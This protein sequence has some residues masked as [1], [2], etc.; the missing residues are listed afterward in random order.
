MSHIIPL[1]LKLCVVVFPTRE[2]PDPFSIS[3]LFNASYLM[4]TLSTNNKSSNISRSQSTSSMHK[5]DIYL[6]LKDLFREAVLTITPSM[7]LCCYI[8]NILY[9]WDQRPQLMAGN[10]ECCHSNGGATAI[11]EGQTVGGT[12][13]DNKI[14]HIAS[15]EV[16]DLNTLSKHWERLESEKRR[17]ERRAAA[18]C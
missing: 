17:W 1:R 14:N 3:A 7:F 5:R 8:N 6:R 9:S 18:V 13:R 10:K 11:T 16:S 2:I 12:L 15:R 4:R